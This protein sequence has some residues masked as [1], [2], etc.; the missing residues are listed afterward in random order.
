MPDQMVDSD[1]Y[2]RFSPE[3]YDRRYQSLR[4]DM[5]HSGL[6]ALLIWGSSNGNGEPNGAMNMASAYYVSNYSDLFFEYVLLPLSGAATLFPSPW[7]DP[8]AVKQWSIVDDIR[9]L[10]QTGIAPIVDRLHELRLADSRIGVVGGVRG[11][12]NMP[13]EHY[14]EL[15]R[16]CPG[17][18]LSFAHALVDNRRSVKSPEEL[19]WLRE[20]CRITDSCFEALRR[21]ARPGM[22]DYQLRAIVIETILREGGMTHIDFL[23]ATPM[24]APRTPFPLMHKSDRVLQVGDVILTEISGGYYGYSGQQQRPFAVGRPPTREYRELFNFARDLFLEI[25]ALLRP[26]CT[27]GEIWDCYDKLIGAGYT[28]YGPLL[29][30]WAMGMDPPQIG[31][32]GLRDRGFVFEEGMTVI[33]QPNPVHPGTDRGVFLGNMVVVTKT[34]AESMSHFPLEFIQI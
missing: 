33:V 29:H 12:M 16:S 10:P 21:D 2:P 14:Q 23:A 24:D 8:T 11:Q 22:H 31:S 1:S 28:H 13:V 9:R 7:T 27:T 5:A 4:S 19:E 32:G 26:G 15:E 3:E 20:G 17:I 30:G 25:V 34:G 6:D 18:E